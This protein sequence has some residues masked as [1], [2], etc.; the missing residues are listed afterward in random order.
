MQ[1]KKLKNQRT[2]VI[3]SKKNQSTVVI[4]GCKLLYNTVHGF[5]VC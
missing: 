4:D 5:W 2:V 3:G 1:K